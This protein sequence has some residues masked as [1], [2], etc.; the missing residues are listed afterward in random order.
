L[1]ACHDTIGVSRRAC[2]TVSTWPNT[3]LPAA[4]RPGGNLHAGGHDCRRGIPL[5]GAAAGDS[6]L[7]RSLKDRAIDISPPKTVTFAPFRVWQQHA[8]ATRN[9]T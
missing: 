5:R 2:N 6:P 8:V 4:F 3:T 7:A 9:W 1:N